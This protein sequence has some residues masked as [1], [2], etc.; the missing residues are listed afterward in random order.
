MA[1]LGQTIV[2]YIFLALDLISRASVRNTDRRSWYTKSRA[3]Y[4]KSSTRENKSNTRNI[5]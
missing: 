2:Y 1:R 4:I 5:L 3:R